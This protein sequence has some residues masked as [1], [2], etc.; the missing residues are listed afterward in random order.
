[1]QFIQHNSMGS[2]I[3][4]PNVF[5]FTYRTPAD[6]NIGSIRFHVAGNA[7][8]GN[9]ANSGDFIYAAEVTL[10]LPASSP[11][12]PF[13]MAARGGVSTATAGTAAPLAVGFAR[14]QTSSGTAGAGLATIS[15]RQA[16]VR[17]S[18]ASLSASAPI[19]SGRTYVEVGGALNTGIALANP[20]SQ[21][22]SVSFFFTDAAGTNFGDSMVTIA[23]NSQLAAFVTESPLRN[24]VTPQKPITDARTFTFN[25]SLPISAA[26]LRT[27]LNER[28]EFMMTALP[29]PDL[30][31]SSTSATS[32]THIADGGGWAMEV[33]LVNN[34]DATATGTLRFNSSSGQTLSVNLDGQTG[35]Q[36]PYS[37]PARTSRRFQTAGSGT[38][39]ATGWIQISPSGNTQTPSAVGV[40]SN[41]VNNVTVSET[42]ITA[43]RAANA[44]R[45]Y[46]ELSGDYAARQAGSTQ[47]GVAV[48]NSGSSE[49]TVN[50]EVTNLDGAVVTSA[51]RSI[52][53]GGQFGLLLGDIPALTLSAPFSGIIWISA[54]AGSPVSV[55]GLRGRY[56]ERQ[57]PD[58]L[59]SSF[60]AFDEAATSPAELL[61][62]HIVD[63]GG[64]ATHFVLLG[65]RSAQSAG[66]LRFVSQSGQA[67]PLPVR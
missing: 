37:I 13:V 27:R 35:N 26:A 24:A 36:F 43:V 28:G 18:E 1:V 44:F 49:V 58:L 51:L 10:S 40:L 39:A 59:V 55:S 32:I 57:T 17:V 54:P 30:A 22:A 15:Y 9:G 66:N 12:R 16:G 41:R 6:A 46:A 33:L 52:P 61:F 67:L 19:R 7:A 45:V 56:N 48:S 23:P 25:S 20:N 62:P 50:V 21:A 29:V 4:G 2:A 38:N 34:S 64:Y 60:P 3:G 11:E 65:V 42:A 47:T 8:N 5:Q 31:A 53:A 14:M 63:S